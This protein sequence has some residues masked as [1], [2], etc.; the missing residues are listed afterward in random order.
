MKSFL[1]KEFINKG[2]IFSFVIK[3]EKTKKVTDFY[4]EKSF[5]NYNVD[6]NK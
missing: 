3:D 1:K 5:P 6:D 4:N 2:G